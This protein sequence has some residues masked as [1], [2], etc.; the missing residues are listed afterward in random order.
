MNIPRSEM[1]QRSVVQVAESLMPQ[2]RELLYIQRLC[3]GVDQGMSALKHDGVPRA[4]ARGTRN[5]SH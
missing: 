4:L 2:L 5:G 3:D 1:L